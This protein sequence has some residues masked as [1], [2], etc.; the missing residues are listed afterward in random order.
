MRS[1][2]GP[3]LVSVRNNLLLLLKDGKDSQ[4][5]VS[6]SFHKYQPDLSMKQIPATETRES[7]EV[8]LYEGWKCLTGS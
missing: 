3:T 7:G 2:R 1:T 5:F 8:K 6:F 4:E